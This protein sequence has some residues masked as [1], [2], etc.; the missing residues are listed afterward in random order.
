[1]IFLQW[2]PQGFDA[3]HHLPSLMNETQKLKMT[4]GC[5]FL[6]LVD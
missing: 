2:G 6:G 3:G 4:D 1:M 5:G